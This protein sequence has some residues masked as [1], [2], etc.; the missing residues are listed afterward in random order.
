MGSSRMKVG[1]VALL[2]LVL[3]AAVVALP[4][5]SEEESILTLLEKDASGVDST[6]A[7]AW[8]KAAHAYGAKGQSVNKAWSAMAKGAHM[9]ERRQPKMQAPGNAV[10]YLR[11]PAVHLKKAMLLKKPSH[12][13]QSL[14][15]EMSG[16]IK[17]DGRDYQALEKKDEASQ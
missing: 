1:L 4:L 15:K 13:M 10:K 7:G 2:G 14:E 16:E 6:T 5:T 8:S 11:A 9:P 17:Q 3:A 12:P